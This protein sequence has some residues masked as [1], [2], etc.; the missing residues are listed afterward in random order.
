MDPVAIFSAIS[1]ILHVA[2]FLLES[3]FF[4]RE[5][6]Y[7]R[8]GIKTT[9]VPSMRVVF[10]NQGFYNLFLAIGA[11]VGLYYYST[12]REPLLLMYVSAYMV[13]AAFV[14]SISKRSMY[15]AAILQ[16]ISPL[17]TLLLLAV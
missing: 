15:R 14:L 3:V 6:V 10:F 17:I 12:F 11:F 16:G 1:G 13:G 8:F 2:F 7:S 9:D 4:T 5:R